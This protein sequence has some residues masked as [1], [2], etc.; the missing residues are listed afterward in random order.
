MPGV[1]FGLLP[2]LLL[3]ALGTPLVAQDQPPP[4]QLA[5]LRERIAALA[6]PDDG[7]AIAVAL[8]EGGELVW[9]E[10]FGRADRSTGRPATADT[11]FRLA[12]ISKPI[13]ATLLMQRVAAGELDLD[14]SLRRVLPDAPLRAH[15]G[16]PDAV[17]LR[18]LC[19]H[20]AGLPTHWQFFF[21]TTPPPRRQSI[22]WFGFCAWAPGERTNYSNL[23]FGIVDA[24]LAEHAKMPFRELVQNRLFGPLRMTHSDLGMPRGE[25]PR[26]VGY[27]AEGPVA[28][29]GFDHDGASAVWCSARDLARFGLLHC[30]AR[31]ASDEDVLPRAA[32]RTMR[33]RTAVAAGSRFGVGWAVDEP[34]GQLRLSHTGGMPGVST[35]LAV[36][37][38]RNAVALVLTNASG[39][40]HTAA[41]LR[42]LEQHLLRDLAAPAAAAGRAAPPAT[43]AP[44]P[45][46]AT[47]IV[48]AGAFTRRGKLLHPDGERTWQ[49]ERDAGGTWRATIADRPLRLRGQPTDRDGVLQLTADGTFALP[50]RTDL[51]TRLVFELRP[52][53]TGDG[54]CGIL[55]AERPG[56]CRLPFWCEP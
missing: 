24:V 53:G 41:L 20:T 14:A 37:P 56:V 13:T 25:V 42:E 55:Y 32:M 49:I 6:A 23:G 48:P 30:E 8:V 2:G 52:A 40:P 19:N 33:Q 39:H 22:D 5:P 17:T 4:A 38:E 29:Y 31:P 1:L 11:S 12:S 47:A 36:F 18:R 28:D 21:D 35:A 15:R 3:G 45:T 27:T 44:T 43:P 46:A 10:G 16:D 7:P 54:L 51:A 26:A 50:G 34:R 9:A